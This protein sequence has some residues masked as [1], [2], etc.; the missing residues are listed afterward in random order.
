M[1]KRGG[2][3]AEFG[4]TPHRWF[5]SPLYVGRKKQSPE[6]FRLTPAQH[7]MKTFISK[8]ILMIGSFWDEFSL[9]RDEWKVVLPT[10]LTMADFGCLKTYDMASEKQL[11]SYTTNLLTDVF[12]MQHATHHNIR[13]EIVKLTPSLC[14]LFVTF[15][16]FSQVTKDLTFEKG[17]SPNNFCC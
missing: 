15:F 1:K 9:R 2:D 3:W 13:N 11:R 16:S 17:I 14:V 12:K 8:W 10:K 7:S 5:S 6:K 4:K